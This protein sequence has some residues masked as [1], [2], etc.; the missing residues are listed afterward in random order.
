MMYK[1]SWKKIIEIEVAKCKQ[2]CKKNKIS[3]IEN[4]ENNLEKK[5]FWLE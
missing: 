5:S 2:S 4:L 1:E 3:G